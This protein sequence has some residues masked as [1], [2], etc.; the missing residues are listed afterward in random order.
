VKVGL[1][2]IYLRFYLIAKG[3]QQYRQNQRSKENHVAKRQN[4]IH[5]NGKRYDA[6]SGAVLSDVS[7]RS[8]PNSPATKSIDGLAKPGTG[9]MTPP[10]KVHEPG[11]LQPAARPISDFARH[12]SRHIKHHAT[13]KSHTLMRSTVKKPAGSLKHRLKSDTHTH[14]LVAQPKVQIEKKLSYPK[15]DSGRARRAVRVPRSEV[16]Q[17]YADTRQLAAPAKPLRVT[18]HAAALKPVHASSPA[19]HAVATPQAASM[20][21]FE[22][23]LHEANSHLQPLVHPGKKHNSQRRSKRIMS[24]G[25]AALSLL[26]IAGFVALQNQA[27]LT[28]HYAS[29]K[30]GITASLPNYRPLGFSV[31][32]FNYSAGTVAV[33]YDNQSSG[34]SFMLTQTASS[35]DSQT[36]KDNFVASAD[37]N[38]Q[39]IQNAG[40]TIYTYGDNNAAWVNGGIMYK[41]TSGGSLTS[42]E[43]VNLA[44]SM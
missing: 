16:I 22:R 19:I 29:H 2:L 21:V 28:I 11:P 36:L 8:L 15:V 31:G 10:P 1:L 33:Q 23:A 27:S 44:T 12:P 17:R 42:T 34:Q 24:F 25:A 32:K 39:V 4:I 43:L 20:D 7:P 3:K 35:W 38:Y 18:P 41:I 14:A 6:Y 9:L 30:A 26:I 40:R 13:S 5:L 37:K